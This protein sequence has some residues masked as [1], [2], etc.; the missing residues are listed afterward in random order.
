MNDAR[1]VVYIYKRDTYRR[2]GRGKS[3]FALHY[4]KQQCSRLAKQDGLCRQHAEM[5]KR[6]WFSTVDVR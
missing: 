4:N 6:M 5:G 2:T 1:C 3:G